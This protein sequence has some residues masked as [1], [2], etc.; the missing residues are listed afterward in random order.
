MFFNDVKQVDQL[1]QKMVKTQPGGQLELAKGFSG[2]QNR[3]K[4]QIMGGSVGELFQLCRV[5]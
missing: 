1:L 5:Q 4:S 3:K 2:L